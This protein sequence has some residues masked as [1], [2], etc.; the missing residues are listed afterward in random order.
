MFNALWALNNIIVHRLV[1]AYCGVPLDS[2]CHQITNNFKKLFEQEGA[3][4]TLIITISIFLVIRMY[5]RL[6]RFLEDG[7][8]NTKFDGDGRPYTGFI[9]L[10]WNN[11]AKIKKAIIMD[12]NNKDEV[13]DF[14]KMNRQLKKA[15][16]YQK[17]VAKAKTH[18]VK[19]KTR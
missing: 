7:A 4:N 14:W 16:Q 6:T 19:A 10:D 13:E 8:P 2:N 3:E 11:N 1:I 17:R 9:D 12:K 15:K 18:L 5:I